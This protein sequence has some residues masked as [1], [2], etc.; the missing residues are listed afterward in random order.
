[1]LTFLTCI[2]CFRYAS[3]A[4]LT[5]ASASVARANI[6]AK[7]ITLKKKKLLW[8]DFVSF[9]WDFPPSFSL[10]IIPLCF[11][12]LSLQHLKQ[13]LKL[14]EALIAKHNGAMQTRHMATMWWCYV[15]NKNVRN[16]RSY[17]QHWPIRRTQMDEADQWGAGVGG[18][19][20]SAVLLK[21]QHSQGKKRR[22]KHCTKRLYF[23]YKCYVHY[24]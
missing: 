17:D 7:I 2:I 24:F 8:Y 14:L 21:L 9:T 15:T 12:I 1:M 18:A 4:F 6:Y 13:Q 20:K 10:P 19:L 22:E 5:S 16:N 3:K 23:L 11:G